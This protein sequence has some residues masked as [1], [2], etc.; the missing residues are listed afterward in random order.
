MAKKEIQ[1]YPGLGQFMSLSGAVFIDRANSA[2][3]HHSLA[4]AGEA[5]KAR[6]TS[7]WVF[8]EGTRTNKELVDLLPLQE[9]RI[10]P[11]YR[12]WNPYHSCR[13]RELL[14]DVSQGHI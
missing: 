2:S 4:A 7:L 8:P 1:Y 11:R 5:M 13:L 6:K 10:P 9:G 12:V 3:A 14:Q